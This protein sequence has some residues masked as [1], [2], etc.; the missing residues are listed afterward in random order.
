MES[1]HINQAA[2][3]ERTDAKKD[4]AAESVNDIDQ[5][6]GEPRF[7]FLTYGTTTTIQVRVATPLIKPLKPRNSQPPIISMLQLAIFNFGSKNIPSNFFLVITSTLTFIIRGH[8]FKLPQQVFISH[9]VAYVVNKSAL[10]SVPTLLV[11]D[12]LSY[13]GLY[14]TA[15]VTMRFPVEY[16]RVWY[17]IYAQ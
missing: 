1:E 6:H 5:R 3:Q 11:G 13:L 15:A 14:D 2:P 16:K 8:Y 17:D 9:R 7:G 10:W 12:I 4:L